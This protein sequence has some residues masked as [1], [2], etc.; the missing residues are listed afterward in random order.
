MG[1]LFGGLAGGIKAPPS[2]NYLKMSEANSH[3]GEFAEWTAD[4]RDEK[5]RGLAR[6]IR[7][8][9]P[10]SIHSSISKA[11]FK[12]IVSPYAPH[13]FNQPYFYCFQA[14][15]VPLA[16][17]MLEYGLPKVP[18]E[19]TFDEQG[20]LGDEARFFYR[21]MRDGQPAPVRSILSRDPIFSNDK[22]VVPLQA[23]DMLAWHVR[24]N[25]IKTPNA[26]QVPD[27]L[28]ADGRHMAVD[29]DTKWLTRIA[30]GYAQIPG[31]QEL[32]TRATWRKTMREVRRLEEAGARPSQ[33]SVRIGNTILYWRRRGARIL[34]RFAALF[35]RRR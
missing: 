6:I 3:S 35:S 15:I 26:F 25:Y 28:S 7:H 20:E 29:I 18:V 31:T 33:R 30:E 27:F 1:A 4:A 32:R 24:R 19:F 8:F 12:D 14:I 2:I 10:T 17:S 21:I 5:L 13:G 11:E 23:A 34:S 9:G 22:L 16:N